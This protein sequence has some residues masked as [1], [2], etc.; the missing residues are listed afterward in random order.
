METNMTSKNDITGDW[1]QSK[2]N[3]DMFE[4]NFDLIFR[5]PKKEESRIDVI[6]QNGNDGIHYEVE[7]DKST[8]EPVK[9]FDFE[10]HVIKLDRENTNGNIQRPSSDSQHEETSVDIGQDTQK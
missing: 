6:G 3:S 8:G 1:I 2:P 10:K 5:Q 7:L 4:K 9:K